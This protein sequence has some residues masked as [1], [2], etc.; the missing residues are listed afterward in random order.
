MEQRVTNN[1]EIEPAQLKEI[2]R[3]M[4]RIRAVDKAIQAGLSSGKFGFTY[5]PMTGQEAIPAILS[6]LTSASDY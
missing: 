5:W 3:E 6:Q 2:Y 1:L 4:A